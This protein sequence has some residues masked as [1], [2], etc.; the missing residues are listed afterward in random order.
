GARTPWRR[1]PCRAAP[2]RAPPPGTRRGGCPP[3]PMSRM[4]RR[5]TAAGAGWARAA[6][7]ARSPP[8]V[9]RGAGTRLRPNARDAAATRRAFS[10]GADLVLLDRVAVA[11]DQE[12]AAV[13]TVGVLPPADATGEV[14]RVDEFEPGSRPDLARAHQDLRRR[15][16]GVG[17]LVVL[18]EGRH[19][20]WDLGR[21]RGQVLRGAGELR[22]VIVEPRHDQ[23]HDFEPETPV[24]DQLDGVEDVLQH[25]AQLALALIVH[26]LH[27]DLV[28]VA[29]R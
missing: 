18:V 8:G 27:I 4:S 14:A 6:G 29:P 12:V 28:A 9:R 24:V 25:P 22:R 7:S 13:G 19:V 17:H 2:R 23:R 11:L 5:R 21:D 16:I 15:V 26:P 10:V 1:A 3:P 20:P